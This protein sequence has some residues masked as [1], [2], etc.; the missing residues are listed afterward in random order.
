MQPAKASTPGGK[1]RQQFGKPVG[2]CMRGAKLEYSDVG[3]SPR[4]VYLFLI[5][6]MDSGFFLLNN[7]VGFVSTLCM[8]HAG[9]YPWKSTV[10][11]VLPVVGFSIFQEVSHGF[12]KGSIGVPLRR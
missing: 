4:L 7:E 2:V 9:H 10:L 1:E 11:P 12:G 5:C 8:A 6:V 3:L